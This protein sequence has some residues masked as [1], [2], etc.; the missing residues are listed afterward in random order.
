MKEGAWNRWKDN[1]KLDL[2]MG[3]EGVDCIYLVQERDQRWAL[4]N[5][6]MNLQVP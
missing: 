4:V 2:E 6:V 3:L 1:I 5:K